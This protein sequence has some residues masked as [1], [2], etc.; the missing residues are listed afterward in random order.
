MGFKV[1]SDKND[2]LFSIMIR[3][4]DGN[5]CCFCIKS[6]DQGWR[7]TN[8]HF[9]GRSD[10][11]NRFNVNNCDTLCFDC[12]QKNESNKQ[13]VYKT[14]KLKQ[15]GKKLYDELERLHYQGGTKKYGEF[16]KAQLYK[17]LKE[18]YKN[19]DH[20]KSGWSVVW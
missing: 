9:W 4:R 20:L 7:M 17:I 14:W 15:L 8:S 13:G 19:K 10:K 5:K 6:A 3:E 11:H 2:D 18:Q 12:H 1:K 16:E